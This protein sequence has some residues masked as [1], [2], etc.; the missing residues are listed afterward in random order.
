MRAECEEINQRC[1]ALLLMN[2]ADRCAWWNIGLWP[3]SCVPSPEN[4]R[5]SPLPPY[6]RV[7]NP[8]GA[9]TG[10]L[11]SAYTGLPPQAPDVHPRT[12]NHAQR[13]G[14]PQH[15]SNPGFLAVAKRSPELERR[16]LELVLRVVVEMRSSPVSFGLPMASTS[17]PV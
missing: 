12:K 11:C 10:S 6:Q 7:T 1:F 13:V 4:I 9:Q 14:K 3:V 2:T 15:D 8:L 16:Y 5:D 17:L